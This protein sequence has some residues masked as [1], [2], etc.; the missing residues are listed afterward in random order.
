MLISDSYIREVNII[1]YGKLL[2]VACI[3]CD[4]LRWTCALCRSIHG[5][6]LFSRCK[7]DQIKIAFVML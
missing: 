2:F 1:Y 3:V 7:F 4:L 5:E 6:Q